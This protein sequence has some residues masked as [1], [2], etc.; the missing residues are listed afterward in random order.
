MDN[1]D[2][3]EETTL[4]IGKTTDVEWIPPEKAK[5]VHPSQLSHAQLGENKKAHLFY[6]L[7]WYFYYI[8]L[9]LGPLAPETREFS[10]L[11]LYIIV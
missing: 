4:S 5:Q 10:T 7:Y 11:H 2:S 6:F 8:A 3:E 9:V 1:T